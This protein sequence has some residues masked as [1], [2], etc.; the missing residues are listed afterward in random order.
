MCAA[1]ANFEAAYRRGVS[2]KASYTIHSEAQRFDVG[3][4]NYL[5]TFCERN[6]Y[7]SGS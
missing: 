5:S 1:R 7:N 3:D 2:L 4:K 6:D